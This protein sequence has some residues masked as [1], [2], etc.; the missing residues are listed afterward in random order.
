MRTEIKRIHNELGRS[1]VYVT[2]DQDEALS[3]ADRIVVL[4]EGKTQQIGKPEELYA[5]P[6]NLEVA[7]FMGY[8]NILDLDAE[9][10]DGTRVALRGAGIAFDGTAQQAIAPGPVTVALRPD[11]VEPGGTGANAIEARVEIVEYCG[12]DWLVDLVLPDGRTVYARSSRKV[13]S[14]AS[15]RCAVP[16]ERVLVFPRES[17]R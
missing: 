1:T 5:S 17:R 2:H 7:R 15:A 8:R 6:A 9:L 4:H 13:A 11:D 10:V 12:R 3:L 14:G 16:P